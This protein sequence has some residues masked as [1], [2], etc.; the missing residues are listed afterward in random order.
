MSSFI[1]NVYEL[2][3]AS[4]YFVALDRYPKDIWKNYSALPANAL[5]N[6]IQKP[7]ISRYRAALQATASARRGE[8]ALIISHLPAMSVATSWAM[9][10]TGFKC[11]HFAF[12]FNFTNLPTKQRKIYMQRAFSRI[13]RFFVFSQFEKELYSE[14][15][16]IPIDK[17]ISLPWTQ[18]PPAV[19]PWGPDPF[20]GDYLCAVGGEGR[21]YELLVQAAIKTNI[22]I[23]IIGRSKKS[24][25]LKN[26]SRIIF[27]ENQP[28]DLTWW[29]AKNS[30][31]MILPLKTE[32]TC[33]GQITL[34]SALML[35]IPIVT[36]QSRA[37]DEYQD[38]HLK[39]LQYTPGNL[40]DLC[41]QMRILYEDWESL[42]STSANL[43]EHYRLKFNRNIWSIK[44]EQQIEDIKKEGFSI[45][46][47]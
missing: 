10:L 30:K 36:A 37:L 9:K 7:K 27:L 14:Y 8:N 4:E 38:D 41:L 22:P 19:R 17:L 33:C 28:S 16:S 29:Y 11:P 18:P 34:V 32:S 44:L 20:N 2:S 25:A 3:P 12:S 39:S 42:K 43:A 13:D 21:D 15:F 47:V 1:H 46:H 23:I 35:G 5:E 26:H 31:G 45:G 6:Y 24:L 40:E